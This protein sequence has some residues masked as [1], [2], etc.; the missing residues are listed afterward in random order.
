MSGMIYLGEGMW[1]SFDLMGHDLVVSWR[2]WEDDE[3]GFRRVADPG[4]EASD[5][6]PWS[7]RRREEAEAH[8]ET[9]RARLLLF[10]MTLRHKVIPNYIWDGL[11]SP[12]YSEEVFG[13]R[14]PVWEAYLRGWSRKYFAPGRGEKLILCM[15][16]NFVVFFFLCRLCGLLF[17]ARPAGVRRG[18]FRSGFRDF[19]ARVFRSAL[20]R[21]RASSPRLPARAGRDGALRGEPR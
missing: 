19:P 2:M 14:P 9:F 7:T 10:L 6:G 17:E 4:F 16:I 8:A 20:G 13:P 12:R 18:Q 5:L 15:I 1:C 11:C 3:L 21:G